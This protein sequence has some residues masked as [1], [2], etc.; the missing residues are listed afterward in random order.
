VEGQREGDANGR[1]GGGQPFP[2]QGQE[3]VGRDADQ[4]KIGRRDE[5]APHLRQDRRAGLDQV[6]L[7][8]PGQV[9]DVPVAAGQHRDVDIPVPRAE[10]IEHPFPQRQVA[11]Q[12]LRNIDGQVPN[13]GLSRLQVGGPRRPVSQLDRCRRRPGRSAGSIPPCAA[14]ARHI[15]PLAVARLD[16]PLRGQQRHRPGRQSL[17][18]PVAPAQFLER[19][20]SLPGSKESVANLRR[21]IGDHPFRLRSPASACGGNDAR[22]VRDGLSFGKPCFTR[23]CRLCGG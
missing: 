2:D 21:K 20:K 4:P 5:T 23:L 11:G 16:Q 15:A 18:H 9:L 1:F 7:S 3:V 14:P 19:G 22:H 12:E 8:F 13:G 10:V 17:A 6:D